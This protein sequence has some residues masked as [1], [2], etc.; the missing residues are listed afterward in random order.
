MSHSTSRSS[1]RSLTLLLG[2]L[3]A[4]LAW[5]APAYASTSPSPSS[6][7]SAAASGDGFCADGAGVSVV[8]DGTAVDGDVRETCVA[9]DGEQA[10]TDVLE[11]AGVSLAYVQ[12]QPGF[13]CT[14]DELPAGQDCST[15][16]AGNSYWGL[17]LAAEG[18][19]SGDGSGDGTWDYAPV[20]V[21]ELQLQ[22]GD[23]VGFAWQ[24]SADPAPPAAD[25]VAGTATGA[26]PTSDEPQP[27]DGATIPT[28]PGA[29]A[30][31]V[32]DSGPSD[33]TPVWIFYAVVVV[34]AVSGLTFVMLR[35]RSRS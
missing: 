5:A 30:D 4:S 8:V 9:T 23:F 10:A 14:V 15:T 34:A 17:F 20:G 33:G 24:T 32:A 29:D 1:S 26:S 2:V 13:V 3:L 18:S 25:P 21:Q 19:G 16:P 6:S 22:P 7:P 31:A 28:T 11:E 27:N 12:G 35:R